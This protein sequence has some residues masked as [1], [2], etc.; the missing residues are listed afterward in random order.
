MEWKLNV[1]HDVVDPLEDNVDV[2]VDFSDGRRFA[3][4]FF[5]LASIRK[6]MLR[7]STTGECASGLYFWSTF[8]VIV[9]RLSQSVIEEVVEDLVATGEF[10]DAFE[11]IARSEGALPTTS[12]KS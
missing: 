5:T 11:L 12:T 1:L 2:V 3:A 8:P 9:E 7:W 6:L 4:T 10:Q